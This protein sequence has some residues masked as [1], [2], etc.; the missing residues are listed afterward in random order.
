MEDFPI[1]EPVAMATDDFDGAQL[2]HDLP[3][4]NIHEP[5]EVDEPGPVAH[6]GQAKGRFV[7]IL[8]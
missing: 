5:V 1:V 4:P 7:V 2:P 6:V 8:H 3:E